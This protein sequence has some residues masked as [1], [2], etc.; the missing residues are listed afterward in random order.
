[1]EIPEDGEAIAVQV[2][3]LLCRIAGRRG[4]RAPWLDYKKLNRLLSSHV[5]THGGSQID[6]AAAKSIAQNTIDVFV[7]PLHMRFRRQRLND[8]DAKALT[9]TMLSLL[10]NRALDYLTD[11]DAQTRESPPIYA[12]TASRTDLEVVQGIF[13]PTATPASYRAA[14][15]ITR[16]TGF[17]V[18]Y[19]IVVAYTDLAATTGVVDIDPAE[20]AAEVRMPGRFVTPSIVSAA[21]T[22]F[23][24]RLGAAEGRIGVRS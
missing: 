9:I 14:L 7:P 6:E 23:R 1:M 8:A 24:A 17:D 4:L 13:G 3:E 21:L 22:R 20:I 12:S 16:Q 18:D 5:Q 10:G 19:A 2:E 11:S 15:R